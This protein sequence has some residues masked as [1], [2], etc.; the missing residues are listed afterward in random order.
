MVYKT[1]DTA[2]VVKNPN[3]K[4][5]VV[6]QNPIGDEK[7]GFLSWENLRYFKREKDANAFARFI[8]TGKE[9]TIEYDGK[10]GGIDYWKVVKKRRTH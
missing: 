5:Y 2:K 10:S 8:R 6:L 7:H 9:I 3:R 4:G 1:G